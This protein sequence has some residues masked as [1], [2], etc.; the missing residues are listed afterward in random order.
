MPYSYEEFFMNFLAAN[1]GN[2]WADV[3][4]QPE[5]HYYEEDVG[6]NLA[7]PT[8]TADVSMSGGTKS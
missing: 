3:A 5:L 8:L 6:I 2:D 1:W 4:T 7:A